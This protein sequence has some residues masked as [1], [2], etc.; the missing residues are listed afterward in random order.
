MKKIAIHSVPRSGSS[1]VGQ[2]FNSSQD[3]NFRF[4]PLFSYTFKDYLNQE[5]SLN[6]VDT[7]FDLINK[8]DDDFLLQKDKVLQGIYPSFKKNNIVTH[9]AYK[10]VRY[11]HILENMMNVDPDVIVIGIIRNP[12]A[13]INSFLN[14]PREF[15]VDLS[16][17]E[18]DEWN[19]ADKKNMDKP[20]EFFGYQKWKEVVF[21]FYQLKNKYSNRFY[22]VKYDDLLANTINVVESMFNFCDIE[23]TKQTVDFLKQSTCLNQG[24]RYSVYKRKIKDDTW[25]NTLNP[26]IIE[27]ITKDL[28]KSNMDEF[29]E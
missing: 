15:R 11:H 2:I 4:Q 9:T 20:E 19:Y 25:R 29:I 13:V 1:W 6:D 23:V 8:S 22:L 3:V 12:Y 14:T 7:F 21:L 28:I 16:W 24:D 26:R 27:A 5:S 10:E 18:L 17:N